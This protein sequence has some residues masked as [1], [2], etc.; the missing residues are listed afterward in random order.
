MRIWLQKQNEWL[1][2]QDYYSQILLQKSILF[3]LGHKYG[4]TEKGEHSMNNHQ[5][6]PTFKRS[7]FDNFKWKVLE[8]NA[9]LRIS[10]S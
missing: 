8:E 3:E 4:T 6:S 2:Y 7:L 5:L 1:W 10:V 9:Q